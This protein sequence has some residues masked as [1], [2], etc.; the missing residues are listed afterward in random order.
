MTDLLVNI[1]FHLDQQTFDAWSM[2]NSDFPYPVQYY[3]KTII[4]SKLLPPYDGA[5]G[6]TMHG[7]SRAIDRN[8][9][10]KGGVAYWMF[11]PQMM[12]PILS[13]CYGERISKEW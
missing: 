2:E 5:A 1:G 10:P 3:D 4:V 7:I 9:Y 11:T 6:V 12:F 8:C 13:H